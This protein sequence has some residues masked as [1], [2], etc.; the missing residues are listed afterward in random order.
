MKPTEF[1]EFFISDDLDNFVL[2]MK[3]KAQ[4]N[5]LKGIFCNNLSSFTRGFQTDL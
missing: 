3:L 4:K 5:C 1:P 2:I